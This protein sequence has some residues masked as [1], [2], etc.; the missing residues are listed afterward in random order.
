MQLKSFKFK[1]AAWHLGAAILTF[2]I[3]AFV[4]HWRSE[5]RDPEASRQSVIAIVDQ[6]FFD[7]RMRS[8]GTRPMSGKVGILAI[9]EKSIAK[10]GRWPFP[11]NSYSDAFKNL[12]NAGV[13]WLGFDVLFSEPESLLLN[14]ALEPLEGILKASLSPSGVLDPRR[15]AQGVERL[16]QMSPGDASLGQ[17]IREFGNVVQAIALL[18]SEEG[19]SLERPWEKAR[20]DLKH[21]LVPLLGHQNEGTSEGEEIVFPLMNTPVIAGEKPLGGFINNASDFDGITRKALLIEE[22]SFPTKTSGRLEKQYLPSLSLQLAAGYLGRKIKVDSYGDH[23]AVS[24][25]SPD[26]SVLQIPTTSNGNDML[27]NHYGFNTNKLNVTTPIQISLAD[28]AEN[29][30]PKDIPDILLLG[31]TTLGIDDKRPSPLNSIANGVEH[32]LA[33]IENIIRND[34]L[35]RNF[36]FQVTEL[37]LMLLTGIMICVLLS[38][39]SALNSL[40]VL[41]ATHAILLIVDQKILFG[42]NH[43]YNLALVHLQ[44]FAI[45]MTMT[46]FKYFIEEK[47]KRKVKGAFQHYLN[48]AVINQLLESP[49][50]LKL[51]GEKRVLTVFFSDVRG[52]TTISE[53]LSPEALASL[54]N[55]YFTPMTNIVLESGGLLDKYIGDALMAVWGAPLSMQDHADKALESALKMLNA[56]DHLRE[57][58]KQKNL[59]AID[60]GCGINTGPMV[61]G[62]MGSNQ[63]FDYTVL[64]DSVNLGSRLE[65][66]T[67]EY[68]V[69]IICSD[70]TRAQ[71]QRP[72]AFLLRELDWI[73]VKGKNEHVTI[74]EVMRFTSETHELA[75]KIKTLFED[76]LACYRAS[77]FTNAQMKMVQILQIA[78]QDG[79]AGVFA[80]R[81]EYFLQNAPP[82]NWDGIWV[83][84]SK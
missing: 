44:N 76:G 74:F 38:H 54:L 34:F 33:L 21:S 49:Q 9:D 53:R 31:T 57:G 62:N 10:F 56:L 18:P 3:F 60:I 67:K 25:V 41:F 43:L 79:P 24:L 82:M 37:L 75:L 11:R 55:E 64:G 8:R 15:F 23:L 65:G 28:A 72:N 1:L 19:Q 48:P 16:L 13:Q 68:G 26:G 71:L 51:G 70:M 36:K 22:V 39:T 29:K 80:E 83:M 84:K 50:G 14:D 47:E 5:M 6:V 12:K 61:V 69:R 32:H 2:F 81:C 17:A 59:P 78:P 40:L 52:F 63:R 58:W 20:E 66:I 42:R 27:I 46:L 45:F 30:L 4:A 7:W 77:D 73:K 35:I